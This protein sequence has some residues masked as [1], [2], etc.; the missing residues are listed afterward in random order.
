MSTRDELFGKTPG[1]YYWCLHCERTYPKT[2]VVL[3]AGLELCPYPDCDGDAVAD[4]WE[5]EKVR[6][7][8]EDSVARYPEFPTPGEVYPLYE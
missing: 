4:A 8:G 1:F 5:W 3:H 7:D 6:Y 2:S